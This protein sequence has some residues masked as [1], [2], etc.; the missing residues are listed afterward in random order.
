MTTHTTPTRRQRARRWWRRDD[1]QALGPELILLVIMAIVIWGALSWLGRLTQTAQSIENAAQSAARAASQQDGIDDARSAAAA[2]HR[3]LQHRRV[4]RRPGR[5]AD[6]DTR[7]DRNLARWQ[8]DRRR[9][10]HDQQ[11]RTPH[12]RRQH[13]PGHRYPSHRPLPELTMPEP[14]DPDTDPAVPESRPRR[15]RMVDDRGFTGVAATVMLLAALAGGGLIF[16][17]GRAL[18]ARRDAIND[19]EAAARVGASQIG[20]GG[21]STDRATQAARDHLIAAG[22]APGDIARIDVNGTTVTVTVTARRSA[23]FTSLLGNDTIVVAG[24]GEATASFGATP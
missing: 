11:H 21:L 9:R 12:Q 2:T 13:T 6:L 8:R 17:G 16:D 4:R 15:R 18:S 3:E 23:V 1:G 24:V 19:A 5:R 14:H 20:F 10:V 22:V 7:A